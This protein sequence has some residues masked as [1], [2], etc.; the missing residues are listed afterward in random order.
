M[1]LGS[2]MARVSHRP[3]EGRGFDP[4]LGLWNRFSEDRAWRTF[5]YRSRYLQ[6]P[7]FPKYI[8]QS[9]L[10]H[11][12]PVRRSLSWK[13]SAT[14]RISTSHYSTWN[15]VIHVSITAQ[16]PSNNFLFVNDRFPFKSAEYNQDAFRNLVCNVNRIN[17]LSFR[18][19]NWVSAWR[20]KNRK[21]FW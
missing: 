11:N 14:P 15:H 20:W 6:A 13:H 7:K 12:Q 8:S 1:N 2:S 19:G 16:R 3:S 9:R 10:S 21:V 5:I 18:F 4:R 17:C